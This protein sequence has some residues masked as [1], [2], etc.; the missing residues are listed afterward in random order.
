MYPYLEKKKHNIRPDGVVPK[1]KK[2]QQ[3]K[4]PEVALPVDISRLNMKVGKII[5]CE[6]HPDADAL[7]LET[8]ECGEEKPRQVISGLVKFIPIDQMENRMVYFS[9][10]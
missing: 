8:I 10:L 3:P 2:P 1:E 7:Y 5:K 6:K 4:E 9:L